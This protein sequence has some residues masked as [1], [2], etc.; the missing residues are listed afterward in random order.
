M[1]KIAIILTCLLV[2]SCN[3]KKPVFKTFGVKDTPILQKPEEIDSILTEQ[4]ASFMNGLKDPFVF[5]YDYGAYAKIYIPQELQ[6]TEV[7]RKFYESHVG[8][9]DSKYT[10]AKPITSDEVYIRFGD[11]KI[12]QETCVLGTI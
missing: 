8:F 3:S 7:Q 1:K 10:E 4:A 2:L 5:D 9:T 12:T 6:L 11:L